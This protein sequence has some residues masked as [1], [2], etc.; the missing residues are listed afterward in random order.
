LAATDAGA[1]LEDALLLA[2]V[3]LGEIDATVAT[4]YAPALLP[5]ICSALGRHEEAQLCGVAVGVVGDLA[6]ALGP[7][8]APFAESLVSLLVT[9]LTAPAL[10]RGVKP[11]IVSAL[12]DICLALGPA[13][14]LPYVPVVMGL[15]LQASTVK[16]TD[17]E[18]YDELDWV[19][20]LRESLLEA[21]TC[22]V[23]TL[24]P[25][26]PAGPA[27]TQYIQPL[28]GFLEAVAADPER[29]EVMVRAIGGLLGDLT[30]AFGPQ[31]RPLL[32]ASPW[33]INFFKSPLAQP[34]PPAPQTVQILQ[35]AH[36]ML[37]K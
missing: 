31:V 17:P 4:R 26:T 16:V 7:Q 34:V 10:N 5:G 27:L 6:R 24:R 13:P 21:Y 28:L 1:E 20:A 8:L 37:S 35:W 9:G 11:H 29:S 33:V 25:D 30:D 3:L 23:Q 2:G 18:D 14:F 19:A 36:Q 22:M 32:L 15:L 12:G